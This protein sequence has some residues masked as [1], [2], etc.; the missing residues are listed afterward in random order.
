MQTSAHLSSYRLALFS[1]SVY[2]PLSFSLRALPISPKVSC[3]CSRKFV[4]LNGINHNIIITIC[5]SFAIENTIYMKICCTSEWTWIRQQPFFM[6]ALTTQ[7]MSYT[8]RYYSCGNAAKAVLLATAVLQRSNLVAWTR[9]PFLPKAAQWSPGSQIDRKNIFLQRVKTLKEGPQLRRTNCFSI[10]ALPRNIRALWSDLDNSQDM[11]HLHIGASG[12]RV[13]F[14]HKCG[15]VLA[16][17]GS[18]CF[19]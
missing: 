7:A 3:P 1:P 16:M 15:K 9:E 14:I 6:A 13:H 2:F 11:K 12:V 5:W 8:E 17:I 18:F 4:K 10:I 19:H